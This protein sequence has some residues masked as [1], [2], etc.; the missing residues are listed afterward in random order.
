[1]QVIVESPNP[2][3]ILRVIIESFSSPTVS[4]WFSNRVDFKLP[5]Y[6]LHL[7]ISLLNYYIR[8]FT[9]F[10]LGYCNQPLIYLLPSDTPTYTTFH[11]A[12]L[13][14]PQWL[15][16]TW[17]IKSKLLSRAWKG[18]PLMALGYPPCLMWPFP[19]YVQWN[20]NSTVMQGDQGLHGQINWEKTSSTCFFSLGT[21]R[22]ENS[23][24]TLNESHGSST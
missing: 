16:T 20:R 22:G 3:R 8:G 19:K 10:H 24:M 14:T 17:K 23:S 4:N 9:I 11:T 6:P 7:S 13:K 5:K 18:P 12:S 2:P 15:S 1:M 21:V